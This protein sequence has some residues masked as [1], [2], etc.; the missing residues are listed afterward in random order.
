MPVGEKVTGHEEAL[1]KAMYAYKFS[2]NEVNR[3]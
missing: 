2:E 1:V 3:S